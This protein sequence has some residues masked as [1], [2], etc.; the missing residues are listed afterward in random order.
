M[1][2]NGGAT[3]S[4][5]EGHRRRDIEAVGPIAPRAAGVHQMQCRSRWRHRTGLAQHLGH[6]SQFF[7]V[8][9]LGAEGH[10]QATGEHGVNLGFEPSLHQACRLLS[11][12]VLPL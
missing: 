9:S 12:E 3:G 1:L 8:D 6:P 2:G 10:Q 11:G 7:A 4:S 5:H